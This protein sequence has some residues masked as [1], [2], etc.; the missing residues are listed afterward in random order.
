M[1][2]SDPRVIAE[3]MNSL[4]KKLDILREADYIF[5][6]EI[7]KAELEARLKELEG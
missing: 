6:D 7:A 5:R 1:A 4:E 3:F 2:V